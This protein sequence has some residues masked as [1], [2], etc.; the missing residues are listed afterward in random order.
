MEK[1]LARINELCNKAKTQDLTQ[2]EVEEQKVLREEYIT[3]F[4]AGLRQQLDNTK[5][6]DVNGNMTP[7]K[8]KKRH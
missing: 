7:L 8:K 2:E 5:I 1:L 4:R 3:L 6:K